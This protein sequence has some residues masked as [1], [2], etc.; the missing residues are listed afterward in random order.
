MCVYSGSCRLTPR[1]LTEGTTTLT[2]QPNNSGSRKQ[3]PVSAT[4]TFIHP[5]ALSISIKKFNMQLLALIYIVGVLKQPS[6]E[7]M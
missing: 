7:H 1:Q 4:Y 2:R 6:E 3:T 5:K